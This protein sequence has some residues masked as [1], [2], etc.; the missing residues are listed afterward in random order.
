[1]TTQHIETLIIGAGQAGLTTGYHLQQ[2]GREFLIVDELERLGDNWRH[3]Y[4]S[5]RLFTPAY[6]NGLAGMAFPADDPWSFPHKDE[7]ADFLE[8]YAVTFDLPV[9]LQTRVERLAARRG[10]GFTATLSGSDLTCDHVV[11]ATGSFGRT[12]SVPEIAA[13]LAP[14]VRQLHSSEYRNPGQ[15]A[16]GPALVVGASHSGLDI[17]YELAES[18]P[19]VLAGPTRGRVP[20]EWGSRK[21]KLMF[22]VIRFA[23]EHVLTRRTPMGRRAMQ[24]IRHHGAPQLRVQNHHLAARGVER[25]EHKV[26]GVSAEG[27]PQ[28]DDGRTLEVANVVWCTG[29]HHDWSWLDLPVIGEDGWPVE[30]RGVVDDVPG[31]FFCGLSFQFAFASMEVGGVSRDAEFVARRIAARSSDRA[32]VAA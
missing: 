19:T 5:L 31:L 18:R 3:H 24:K 14:T 12:A 28:L 13:A 10:G 22:P 32:G 6:A 20:A 9:R 25:V 17:A 11:V 1:M 30:Y 27:L 2:R 26:T 23:F 7:M 16:D 21:L 8:Q 4:D 29:F 15:L